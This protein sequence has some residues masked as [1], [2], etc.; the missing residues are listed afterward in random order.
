MNSVDRAFTPALELAESIRTL[1][2]FCG[3]GLLPVRGGLEAQPLLP[4]RKFI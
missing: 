3:T 1:E 2:E 4:T